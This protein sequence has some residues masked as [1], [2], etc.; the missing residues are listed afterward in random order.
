MRC[1]DWL[2][3]AA[4]VL[5]L[6]YPAESAAEAPSDPFA[7]TW[8]APSSCPE[9][10]E[11]TRQIETFLGQSLEVRRMQQ[12]KIDAVV[13]EDASAGFV[14]TVSVTTPTASYERRLDHQ[15]CARLTEAAAL[16]IAL[17]IDPERV[18]AQQAEAAP[19]K[20]A[21]AAVAAPVAPAPSAPEAQP[22]VEPSAAAS[23]PVPAAAPD[24]VLIDA[25]VRGLI[26]V[27]TLPRAGFG[28]GA[29]FGVGFGNFRLELS[30]AYWLPVEESVPGHAPAKVEIQLATGSLL[31]CGVWRRGAWNLA[32]CAGAEAGD[33][34][35]SGVNLEDPITQHQ[36]WSAVVA[37]LRL[38]LAL[39][40]VLRV[41]GGLEPGLALTRPRFGVTQGDDTLQVAQ[42]GPVF[43]RTYLGATLS[44]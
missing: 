20:E 43:L 24:P 30:G 11:L 42:P 23:V 40:P 28:V 26:D 36:L 12:L 27:G 31:G 41:V 19:T 16:V 22:T 35:G 38:S 2:K 14:A 8:Q 7:L 6:L 3:A 17:A 34:W 4:L 39:T 21:D 5:L 29:M 15:D 37:D 32:A 25:G 1:G 13:H 10:S 9:R 33:Y 44:F 18:R